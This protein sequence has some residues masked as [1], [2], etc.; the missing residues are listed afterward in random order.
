MTNHQQISITGASGHL[1]TVLIQT[2]LKAG[3]KV[4]GLYRNTPPTFSHTNLNWIQG[5]LD[6]SKSLHKLIVDSSTLIH[7]AS[8]IS[9][10]NYSDDEVLKVNVD[11]TKT[12]L[13]IC[14]ELSVRMIYISSSNAVQ[15]TIDETIFDELRPYKTETDFA[16]SYSKAM[17]EHAVLSADRQQNI[18]AFIIRPSAIVGPPDFGPSHF[19]TT[20]LELAKGKI[21]LITSGGYNIVDIRDLSNTIVNSISLGKSGEVYLVGGKY[22]SVFEISKL[23]NPSK[24]LIQLPINVLLWFLPVLLLFNKTLKL[25]LPISKE[26]LTTL[27]NAPKNMSSAKAIQHLNH[28]IRPISETINDLLDWFKTTDKL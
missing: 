10:G 6:N 24:K 1:G 5:S 26:S 21:P 2:L 17:A 18:D 23:A 13:K 25:N 16:Y 22:T 15:E 7:C 19:G 4:K 12:V 8:I 14:L 27:K 11:G 9:L 20:I 3:Y 28:Q